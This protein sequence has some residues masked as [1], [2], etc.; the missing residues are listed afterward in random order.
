LSACGGGGDPASS[1][2]SSSASASVPAANSE[3][4]DSVKVTPG[5]AGKAPTVD[6][7]KPLNMPQIAMKL[8]NEGSGETVVAGQQ[9]TL[10]SASF[11][12]QDGT[13]NG[14]SFSQGTGTEILLDDSFKAQAALPYSV[15][16]GAKV[17]A[18]FAYGVPAQPAAQGATAQP[19][20]IEVY[21]IESA[22]TP[23]PLP[24]LATPEESKQLDSDGKLP[25]ATFDDKGVPSIQVPAV[26]PPAN[27][28]VK[29]L[30]EGSGDALKSTDSANVE[31]TGWK[32][33]DPST[34]FDSNYGKG[35]P[36]KVT[37]S[38]GVIKGW[39]MGLVDQKVGSTVMLVIPAALGYGDNPSGGQPGGTLVFVVNIQAKA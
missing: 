14:E 35:S 20:S 29:V 28:V 24:T 34:P 7:P 17:G 1:S 3:L 11:N 8:T 12:A 32:W 33:T 5:E 31:Y 36:F 6:F 26:D 2:A 38:G 37:L 30:K 23:P 15:I 22:K 27:L 21:Y 19:A 13:S 9:V 4:L 39:L 25:S 10:R 16:V 18:Y